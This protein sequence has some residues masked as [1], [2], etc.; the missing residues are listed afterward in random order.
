MHNKKEYELIKIPKP[1][2][3]SNY[4]ILDILCK[5]SNQTKGIHILDLDFKDTFKIVRILSLNFMNFIIKLDF[6]INFMNFM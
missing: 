6:M 4:L 1:E 5:E 2:G 3:S